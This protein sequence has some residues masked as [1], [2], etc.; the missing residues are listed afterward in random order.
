MTKEI[1]KRLEKLKV[2]LKTKDN[3]L[4]VFLFGSYAKDLIHRESDI[5]IAIYFKPE[6]NEI[7]YEEEKEYEGEDELWSEIEKIL[8]IKCC[9][10]P[11]PFS[12]LL[13]RSGIRT[14]IDT[15]DATATNTKSGKR[16]A[17]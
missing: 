6:N 15:I 10:S 9:A 14:E 8:E 11:P 3:I 1:I 12:I 2:F 13:V 5:D 16:N 17:A 7:E 4:A